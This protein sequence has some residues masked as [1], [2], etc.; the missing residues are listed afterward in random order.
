MRAAQHSRV[1]AHAP[2]EVQACAADDDGRF[3][4]RRNVSRGGCS[5]VCPVPD[6]V[7]HAGRHHV[8]HVVRHALPLRRRQLGAAHV[9]ASIHLSIT[10]RVSGAATGNEAARH[11]RRVGRTCTESAEMT[12]PSNACASASDSAVLPLAVGPASTSTRGRGRGAGEA[13]PPSCGGGVAPKPQNPLILKF[14]IT[15]KITQINKIKILS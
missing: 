13:P 5:S 9:Q 12:S 11:A 3:A 2:S 6:G 1:Y 15:S 10:C 8:Q 4:S 14:I 7:L